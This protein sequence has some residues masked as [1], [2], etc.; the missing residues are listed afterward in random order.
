MLAKPNL[1]LS[2]YHSRIQ[3]KGAEDDLVSYRAQFPGST[4]VVAP[5][6]DHGVL[7]I[8]YGALLV[9]VWNLWLAFLLALIL[10]ACT[11]LNLPARLLIGLLMALCV[12]PS[13]LLVLFH[14]RSDV[15]RMS[16]DA[17]LFFALHGFFVVLLTF[18]AFLFVQR[19]VLKRIQDLDIL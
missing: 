18:A 17:F 12:V 14:F 6:S 16:E 7:T 1:E 4:L 8:P 5:K 15:Q 9:A 13:T 11:L 2:I 19:L 3:Q 10:Q